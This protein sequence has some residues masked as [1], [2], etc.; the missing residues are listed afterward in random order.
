MTHVLIVDDE[1]EIRDVLRVALED[2]GYTVSEVS[3]GLEGL[4]ALRT[5]SGSCVVL[6]DQIMPKL[7]GLGLLRALQS[8]LEVARRHAYL[9][10]T[11]R[12][13]LSLPVLGAPSSIFL[14]QLRKPF[15]LDELLERI[16]Q[17]AQFLNQPRMEA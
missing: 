7:D 2:A 16:D 9:L 15:D 13:R 8:E 17:A 6:L 10:L 3:N 5:A 11:A 14:S 12:P 4:A 1:Q